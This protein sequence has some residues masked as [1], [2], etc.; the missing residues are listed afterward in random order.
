MLCRE[1]L[2]LYFYCQKWDSQVPFGRNVFNKVLGN[3]HK[4]IHQRSDYR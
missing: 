4:I 2:E 1:T 3:T